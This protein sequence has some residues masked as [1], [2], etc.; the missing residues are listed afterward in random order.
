MPRDR[1]E[2]DED[3][4]RPRRR[5]RRDE[6]DEDDDR[7]RRPA[8][9]RSAD[10]VDDAPAKVT[11]SNGLATMSLVFG[12]LSFCTGITFIPGLICGLMGLSKART[13]G[14][15]KG[16][17]IAGILTSLV[18]LAVSGA[19]AAGGYF[20]YVQKQKL[21]ER[22]VSNNSFKQV[23]IATHNNSDATGFLPRPYLDESRRDTDPPLAES[24]LRTKLSW[25][26]TL[27]P[28]LEQ[29]SLYSRFQRS[30]TWDS[31]PNKPLSQT[32]VKPYA[33][34]DTPLDPATRV[35]CFYDNGA[36]F[37]SRYKTTFLSITDGTSNTILYVEGGDKGTWSQFNEYK[38]EPNGALPALG[39]PNRDTFTVILAD[40]STRQLRKSINPATLKALITRAAGDV[41][42]DY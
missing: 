33:D 32:V 4:D 3:D 20:L 7:P 30:E 38:F 17:A 34:T 18:G 8:R 26:V 21:E 24:A 40:G 2:D 31:P 19:A 5:S 22:M 15:G 16:L 27:L 9:R 35:R 12:I 6:D 1:Y 10:D 37:D 13:S 11:G 28:Y 23:G 14:V 36:I 29:A 42:G 39:H 25:R 41:I